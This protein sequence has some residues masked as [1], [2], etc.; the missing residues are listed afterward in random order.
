MHVGKHLVFAAL[1]AVLAAGP[2]LAQTSGAPGTG[3]SGSVLRPTDPNQPPST[4][5]STPSTPN[6]GIGGSVTG[7]I[8]GT[9]GGTPY[10]SGGSVTGGLPGTLGGTA[11]GGGSSQSNTSIG[12]A[13]ISTTPTTPSTIGGSSTGAVGN[14]S[15][16]AL[17]GSSS[18]P[19]GGSS[20]GALGSG[21]AGGSTRT[22]R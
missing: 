12:G 7:G 19:L 10:S 14:S 2:V 3:T 1:G 6:T 15:T 11:A 8:P 13:G 16:G 18:G 21:S 4:R 17:G 5:Q 20:S 9:L 22:I